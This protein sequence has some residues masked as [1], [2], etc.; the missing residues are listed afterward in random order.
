[1][2]LADIGN[3][4]FWSNQMDLKSWPCWAKVVAV[5]GLV[6]F[7]F[8]WPSSSVEWAA[9]VQAFGS[10]GAVVAAIFIMKHQSRAQME[11]R[12]Q[13]KKIFLDTVTALLEGVG[14]RLEEASKSTPVSTD[15][16]TWN[17]FEIDLSC[18][19]VTKMEMFESKQLLDCFV[20]SRANLNLL[21][22]FNQMNPNAVG[23]AK[24]MKERINKSLMAVNS[25]LSEVK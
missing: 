18:L 13:E 9:W 16:E 24:E 3:K 19:E 4:Y 7:I 11:E 5:I 14:K 17:A 15:S 6:V 23:Y 22:K 10:I 1:M 25:F 2:I 12:L 20:K 21:V 8:N